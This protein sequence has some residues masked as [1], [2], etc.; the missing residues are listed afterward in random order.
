MLWTLRTRLAALMRRYK[1]AAHPDEVQVRLPPRRL[2]R[3]GPHALDEEAEATPTSNP[4]QASGP[5]RPGPEPVDLSDLGQDELQARRRMVAAIARH[6]WKK[7]P[8]A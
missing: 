7:E 5:V 6:G 1:P 4:G 3:G 2:P 8:T